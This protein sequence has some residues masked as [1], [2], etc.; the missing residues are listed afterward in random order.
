MCSCALLPGEQYLMFVSH[1]PAED[2]KEHEVRVLVSSVA[3]GVCYNVVERPLEQ[4]WRK[5]VV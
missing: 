4:R 5:Q 2:V 3:G 1:S